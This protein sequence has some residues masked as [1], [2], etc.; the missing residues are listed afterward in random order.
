MHIGFIGLGN[1]GAP[2]AHNLLNAGHQLSVFDLNAAAVE[3]LVGAGALPVDSPTAIAQGNAELIITMLPAAAHVKSVYL[4]E[5]GLIASSRAGVMLIDCSTIDPHSAREVAKAAAE[6]GNPMLDA[7][8][9]GGTGGAAAGTLTFMVGG[10][11][12]D[13]DR[14][15]PILAA[16]GKNIV[17]CGA[18]GNGQVAK[19]ANNMLLGISMIGVA[20]AMALGVALGM[21]AKT[22]AGVI[23]TSSGRC[24]SS[25]TYNPFPG[26]LDNVP[27]SRG[28]SGGF[29][30]DL[31]LKDLGLA[32]EAAKQVRQPVILGALA[33]QLYQSFSAQGHGGLDFSAIINQYRKDT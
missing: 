5:N 24:W 31:M 23:N 4:G 15:Q 25:D 8:V 11:D 16:M 33:Q 22:L 3:N 19:V 29:G 32:T 9:S 7:P 20:E 13:F 14:A 28:Y 2:M 30:S 1:M 6:H 10:S 21:D 12:A 26:V 17:H 27:A 18:A